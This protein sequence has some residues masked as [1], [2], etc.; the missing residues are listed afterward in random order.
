M[1]SGRLADV[2]L[3]Q[4]HSA[5]LPQQVSGLEAIAVC[6]GGLLVRWKLVIGGGRR[7]ESKDWK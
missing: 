2:N 6:V 4:T 7:I 3:P 1:G 5:L